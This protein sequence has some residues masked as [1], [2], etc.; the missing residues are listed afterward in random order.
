MTSILPKWK[1]AARPLL[2]LL[3]LA[4]LLGTGCRAAPVVVKIGLVAPF[5]GRYRPVGYDLIYSA[6]L[7]V[8]EINSAA[9]ANGVRMAL[10]AL[11]DGGDPQQA[12]AVAAALV[13]DPQIMAV[14][15]HWRPE[16]TAAARELYEGAGLPFVA[17]GSGS[18]AFAPFAPDQL[19]P[20]FLQAY[21]DLTP[22][23]EVAGPYAAPGYDAIYL[24]QAAI[25]AAADRG[26]IDRQS[27]GEALGAV[28]I[29]GLT[30]FV[31]LES[32]TGVEP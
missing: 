29:D 7:A 11:D 22:F 8:R 9:E 4:L 12:R 19:P 31:A 10:V 1:R 30:G 16:S 5:E 18:G 15:G 21:A 27:V 20:A 28:T 23:A 24:L 17:T 3:G 32:T 13:N 14:I 6:R 2:L 25:E 26:T